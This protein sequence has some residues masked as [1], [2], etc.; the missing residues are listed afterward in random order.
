MKQTVFSTPLALAVLLSLALAACV[1]T[2][3]S[4]GE[5]LAQ[6]HFYKPAVDEELFGTWV[7]PEPNPPTV[8]Q[9]LVVYPWGLVEWYT[10]SRR[11]GS[12]DST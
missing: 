11:I 2:G 3:G 4:S 12:S 6:K 8:A 1:T 7:N 5:S 10:R 9:K